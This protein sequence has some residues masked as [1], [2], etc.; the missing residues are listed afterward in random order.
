MSFD[1][2]PDAYTRFMGV[3]SERLA[4]QFV[5]LLDLRSGQRALDVGCGPGVLTAQLADR[6]GCC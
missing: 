4:V 2:T 6:L 3:Y 1:V 5:E